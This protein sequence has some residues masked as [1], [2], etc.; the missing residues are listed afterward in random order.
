MGDYFF[1]KN[2]RKS[3][4]TD[5]KRMR[6]TEIRTRLNVA[7]VL[8][9]AGQRMK[10]EQAYKALLAEAEEAEGFHSLLAGSVLVEL[11]DFYE[12]QEREE[13][14]EQVWKRIRTILVIG[15]KNLNYG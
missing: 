4:F 12:M 13:E 7:K 1:G 8:S 10:A 15:L 3:N 6:E 5:T 2:A 14:A 11:A 9:V